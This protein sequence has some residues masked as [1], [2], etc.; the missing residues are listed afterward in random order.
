MASFYSKIILL[1]AFLTCF[2]AYGQL[3]ETYYYSFEGPAGGTVQTFLKTEHHIIIGGRSVN[4]RGFIIPAVTKIDTLGNSIWTTASIET[5]TTDQYGY[6]HK[7]MRADGYIYAICAPKDYPDARKELWKI[8]ETNGTV[9]WKKAVL[10]DA[11]REVPDHM[12]NY[13]TGSIL[14]SYKGNYDGLRYEI[15]LERINK[16]TGNTISTRL[17]GKPH[18][19]RAGHGLAIDSEKNIYYTIED[20]LFRIHPAIADS[21]TWK[22]TYPTIGASSY[23]HIYVDEHDSVFAFAQQNGGSAKA[24]GISRNSGNLLWSVN[25]Y[26]GSES[27]FQAM[28]DKGGNMYIIWRHVTVGSGLYDFWST[29]INKLSGNPEWNSSISITP[30]GAPVPL[31]SGAGEGAVSIDVD[32]NGDAYLTGYYGDANGSS[33]NW[34]ILKLDGQTGARL[35]DGTITENPLTYNDLSCGQAVCVFNNKPYFVGDLEVYHNSPKRVKPAFIALDPAS[36]S[37]LRKKYIEGEAT[38]HSEVLAI[39]KHTSEKTVMLIQTGRFISVEMHD[40]SNNVIWQTSYQ[41]EYFL[42]G[43]NLVIS[44]DGTII[45]SA[46]SEKYKSTTGTDSIYVFYIDTSG[47]TI[48]QQRFASAGSSFP[49]EMLHDDVKGTFLFY[50]RSGSLFCR[51]ITSGLLSPEYNLNITY[52]TSQNRYTINSGAN[53]LV[54]GTK[55]SLTKIVQLDK[56]SLSTTDIATIPA[57]GSIYDVLDKDAGVVFLCGK[58]GT[59]TA[60]LKYD[61]TLSDTLWSRTYTQPDEAFR[62]RFNEDTSALYLAGK[63]GLTASLSKINEATGQEEWVTWENA[64]SPFADVPKDLIVD[65]YRQQVIM[66][67]Y[68]ATVPDG[69]NQNVFIRRFDK[70]G[71]RL[72]AYIR[73]SGIANSKTSNMC[74]SILHGGKI[75]VGGAINVPFYGNA[76]VM[77]TLDQPLFCPLTINDTSCNSYVSPSG[78]YVWTQSGTY[79]DTVTGT[80][81]SCAH[82]IYT[83]Y[84]TVSRKD[85]T[86]YPAVC[87][88]YISPGGQVWSTSGIYHDTLRTVSGCDSIAYTIHLTVHDTALTSTIKAV[89][90][91]DYLSPS[92]KYLWSESGAYQDTL[93]SI[94][95]CDSIVFTI[96]LTIKSK[97]INEVT[98]EACDSYVSPSGRFVWSASGIYRDTIIGSDGCDS[99]LSIDLTI[100]VVD[101]S[102]SVTN[103]SLVANA[104]EASFQWLDCGNLYASLA[105]DTNS[106]FTSATAGSFAVR[107]SQHGCIDTSACYSIVNSGISENDFGPRLSVFPNPTEGL[108]TIDLGSMYYNITTTAKDLYGQTVMRTEAHKGKVICIDIPGPSGFYFI[109]IESKRQKPVVFKILKK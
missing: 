13:D 78:R 51:K 31:Q 109:S 68:Q 70:H 104:T 66:A 12:I 26:T 79:Q 62:C 35:Y 59:K 82:I 36:G 40:S 17:L 95:G 96:Q 87:S 47:N 101:I 44:P 14:V 24:I 50:S 57:I 43:H 8:D 65:A 81:S 71:N 3:S 99:I 34:G 39:K 83:V 72:D 54:V 103:D 7:M 45:F 89:A 32:D 75:S 90:C 16:V 18:W 105:G 77:Y 55:S 22:T 15:M 73:T 91:N 107:V 10:A 11:G 94:Y 92:K 93:H 48:G 29:K 21:T 6:L 19:A 30:V 67:G 1:A 98:L 9:L 64:S 53:I 23:L 106:L 61:L 42:Y 80:S 20:S 108:L 27:W 52:K 41:K 58:T 46:R 102:V 60:L 86:L 5:N 37:V 28:A 69:V 56:D 38:Y 74:S 49:V 84:L 25:P 97:F 85:T 88:S 100:G 4:S 2:S 33:E 63:R 76:G